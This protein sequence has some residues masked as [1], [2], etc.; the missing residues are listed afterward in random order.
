MNFLSKLA[1]RRPVTIVMITL[2]VVII[3]V[4]SLGRLPIDL[5]PEIEVPVAI[6]STSYE[7]VGPQ[8]IEKMI[9]KPIEEAIA[10][11]GN[12]ENISSQSSE[13]NSIV[14]AEFSF[15][16][17]MDF[18]SLE[19]REKIDL[20]K[21]F[22]PEEASEPMVLKIDPNAMPII[23]LSLSNSGDL[24]KLQT[25]AEDTIKPR[26]E[27]LEGVASVDISGG[28]EK[29]VEIKVN[30]QILE[31]YGIDINYIAQI[32][33]AENL[34]MPGGEVKRG[35]QELT[36]R[37]LG[38]FSSIEE[39]RLL[40][41]TLPSGGVIYLQ[42][43]ADVKLSNKELSSISRTNGSDSINISVQKQSGTNTVKVAE[44]VNKEIEKLKK[45]F[46]AIKINTVMDQ[47]KYIKQSIGNV[48]KNALIGALLAIVVLYI[49]LRNVGTTLIIGTSIPVSVIA[50]FI[51]LY[52]NDI[53]LNMMTLGGLALGVGMLVDNAIVVLENIYRF[54]EEG[55]SRKDAAVKGAS[56]VA[57]AVTASTLTTVAVFL[58]IVFVEGITSTIFKELAMTVTLALVSSLIVSLTLIP[59]LSSKILKVDNHEKKRFKLFDFFYNGFDKM[60]KGIE[61]NY[62]KLLNWALNHRKSTVAISLI[63]FIASMVSVGSVGSEFFPTT[64]EGQFTVTINLPEGAELESTDEIVRK[65]EEKVSKI[66]EIETVFVTV[67]STGSNWAQGNASNSA[68]VTGILVDLNKRQRSTSEV[69]DQV[70]DMLK[71]IPGADKKVEVTSSTMMGLGG[72][73]ISISIKGDDLD[74]LKRIGEDF[75]EIVDSVEGTTEVETSLTEGIP[76]VQIKV[77]RY[78]ASQYGLTAGQ[79]ASAVKGTISGTVASRY[80]YNGDE[81]DVV[82]KGDDTLSQSISNLGLVSIKTPAGVS[83]PLS[84][85]ADINIDRG[86]TE[87]N[88]ED[89]VRVVTV[90]SQ[91]IGRDLGSIS[92]DIEAKLSEYNMPNGYTYEMGGQNKE[93]NESFADLSL[94]LL[95][96][97]VLVYMIIASQFESLLHP[98]TIMLSVPLALAGGALGLFITR[99]PL[100]VPAFI[101]VIILAG[102]VVN[103]AIVLVDYINTRRRKGE[104]RREAIVNAGPIRLR[105]ILMTTLTTVLGLIP[106]A[107]GIGE[108]AELE[109]PLATVV[110]GGLLLSTLLT[111]VFIPVMYTIFDDIGMFLKRK[112]FKKAVGEN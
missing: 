64:D 31:G 76:E 80:K 60:F 88:R 65:V 66:E 77:N 41:I 101:G 44:T 37:T 3:G 94:A 87:I 96:A 27:R 92:E 103:N 1:V 35:K 21:G 25:I 4:V 5:L 71:D 69:A 36:I 26:L 43:I 50:T 106:L 89:Q 78:R 95:L 29:Q 104:E 98:F 17:D 46:P 79:I 61:S 57:M 97:V 48:Y 68:T 55:N 8:E 75:K 9:T 85:V 49:F 32:I 15:G 100:S 42:D 109:A 102:I 99:R 52:F 12:I 107:L 82:I 112:V 18:A 40:P 91:I 19:M 47:S 34:N 33:R 105:P 73:P 67:G 7:G 14:V 54:R 20:V 28:Y 84:Q 90:T 93:L 111:L 74:T 63:I 23:Q 2:I 72:A 16:T 53:T 11:V 83:I 51:L 39:I 10:T 24:A 62:K 6:V 110:I 86:P 38:E 13:G 22:L 70:R 81:I 108:G 59:M 30:Q 56:E 58:P 45:E